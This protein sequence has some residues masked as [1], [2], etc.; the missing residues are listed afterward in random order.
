MGLDTTTGVLGG[1]GN[2]GHREGRGHV[3][4]TKLEEMQL[5]A[6]GHTDYGSPRKRRRARSMRTA[7]VPGS[8]GEVG[9]SLPPCAFRGSPADTLTLTS[10]FHPP[11]EDDSPLVRSPQNV[12][13]C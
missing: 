3:T 7:A 1:R 10:D 4:E 2:L 9:M 11:D 5:Q 6:K 12:G 13:L 8:E